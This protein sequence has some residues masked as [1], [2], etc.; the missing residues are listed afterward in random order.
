MARATKES[1]DARHKAVY[2]EYLRV[3][4]SHGEHGKFMPKTVLYQEVSEKVFYEPNS[5]GIIVREQIKKHTL[6]S[7]KRVSDMMEH[8][9]SI[10]DANV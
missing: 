8:V 7:E 1:M 2:E 10:R 9:K 5:V 3:L 4:E 6:G